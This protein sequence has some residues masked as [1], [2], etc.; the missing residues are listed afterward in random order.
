[1]ELRWCCSEDNFKIH[2][3]PLNLS[4][5]GRSYTQVFQV[6]RFFSFDKH[7]A[8]V[9]FCVVCNELDF[10]NAKDTE[11]GCCTLRR[12]IPLCACQNLMA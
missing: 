12:H 8:S 7:R 2:C 9:T 10:T 3:G 5:L 6:V 4:A 11:S 1:M